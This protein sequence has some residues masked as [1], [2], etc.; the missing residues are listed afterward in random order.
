MHK[1]R[2]YCRIFLCVITAIVQYAQKTTETL[3]LFV[4]NRKSYNSVTLMTKGYRTVTKELQVPRISARTAGSLSQVTVSLI[5]YIRVK[6][7]Q[8]ELQKELRLALTWS[9]IAAVGAVLCRCRATKFRLL[10]FHI[11]KNLLE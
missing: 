4:Q 3:K 1:K 8:K 5:Y 11:L 7:L 2:L 9:C 6:E 10:K